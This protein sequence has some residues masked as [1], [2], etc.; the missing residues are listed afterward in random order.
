MA[1][2]LVICIRAA[3]LTGD[4]QRVFVADNGARL[5]APHC[6]TVAEH[7]NAAFSPIRL[8]GRDQPL[9]LSAIVSGLESLADELA[10][11]DHDTAA[12]KRQAKAAGQRLQELLAADPISK[13]SP[14][15]TATTGR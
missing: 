12:I 13:A 3:Y 5:V 11:G 15:E 1:Q 7:V 6:P 10:E 9:V 14:D 2:I 4:P 8:A